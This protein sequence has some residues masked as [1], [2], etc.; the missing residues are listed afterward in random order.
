MFK[1]AIFVTKKNVN[2]DKMNTEITLPTLT[3]LMILN[4]NSHSHYIKPEQL[5]LLTPNLIRMTSTKSLTIE[6]NYLRGLP[7]VQS[8][9]EIFTNMKHLNFLKI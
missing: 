2:F 1:L 7:G 8:L 3:N 6:S 4:L 9:I 5:S